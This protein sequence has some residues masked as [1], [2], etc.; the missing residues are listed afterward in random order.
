MTAKHNRIK[1]G[2]Y[3]TPTC[4]K[5]ECI[6]GK[7]YKYDS[8]YYRHKK[9]CKFQVENNQ[10]L[11]NSIVDDFPTMSDSSAVITLIKQN[12]EFKCLILEQYTHL[13]ESNQKN[14]ELQQQLVDAVKNNTVSIANH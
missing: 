10:S 12:Q 3:K 8:G 2:I 9:K 7:Y 1:N 14:M 5:Y 11:T 4:E 6:C 13:H